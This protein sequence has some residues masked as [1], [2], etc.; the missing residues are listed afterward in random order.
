MYQLIPLAVGIYCV[1]I[2]HVFIALFWYPVANIIPREK[3]LLRPDRFTLKF[4]VK[5]VF[6][7][8]SR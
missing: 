6:L 8:M 2:C 7:K 5:D 4:T 1:N 3:I